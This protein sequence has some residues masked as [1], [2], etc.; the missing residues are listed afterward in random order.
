MARNFC[1]RASEF[2]AGGAG[3]DDSEGEPRVAL[4]VTGFAFS[5]FKRK[6]HPPAYGKRVFQGFKSWC[7]LGPRIVAEIAV[8]RARGNDQVIVGDRTSAFDSDRALCGIDGRDFAH[9]YRDVA[10]LAKNMTYGRG[11][12][13]GRQ[14]RRSDLIQQRLKQVMVTAVDDGD[15]HG[16]A[17]EYL[18]RFQSAEAATDNDHARK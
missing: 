2:H 7:V 11:N 4:I 14:T 17:G 13:R 1:Q 18:G 9:E 5:V 8:R 15:L 6:Q 10:L 12:G 3:A 16:P